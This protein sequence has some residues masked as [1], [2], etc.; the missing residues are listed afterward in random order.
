LP[1]L[2]CGGSGTLPAAA[3][4]TTLARKL[5]AA[6]LATRTLSKSRL[7]PVRTARARQREAWHRRCSTTTASRASARPPA[8]S[9]GRP[10][11]RCRS[12]ASAIHRPYE[13]LL[14]SHSRPRP[15]PLPGRL[16]R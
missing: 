9:G 2:A 1:R 13:T 6:R 3:L 11:A 8:P 5:R 7:T 14:G 15:S 10:A 16:G 4:A 12:A